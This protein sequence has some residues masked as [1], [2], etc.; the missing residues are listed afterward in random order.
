MKNMKN[1]YIGKLRNLRNIVLPYFH[2][3]RWLVLRPSVPTLSDKTMLHLGCGK[4]NDRNFINIDAYPY[5]HVH[6]IRNI[7]SKRLWR[8]N[9]VDFIYVSHAL[10]HVS[11]ADLS[12]VLLNWCSYLRKG[13]VLRLS[14][15]DFDSLVKI[16]AIRNNNIES[17]LPPLMGGQVNKYDFHYSVFNKQ[18]LLLLLEVF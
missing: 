18:Y 14:V 11:R 6:Y 4:I 12:Q 5:S 17:I 10:E 9:S 8:K 16:Y 13:G 2:R 3:V 15:P 7:T 1:I